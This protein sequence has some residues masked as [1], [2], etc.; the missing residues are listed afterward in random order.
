MAGTQV[1]QYELVTPGQVPLP[2]YVVV[3]GGDD[4][5]PVVSNTTVGGNQ[6]APLTIVPELFS[7]EFQAGLSTETLQSVTITALPA[8][9]TLTYNGAAVGV[10]ETIDGWGW[11][12]LVYTPNADYAGSDGFTWNGSDGA[13]S[14]AA[15]ATVGITVLPL[16]DIAVRG[17]GV[18]IS[19]GQKKGVAANGTALV[20]ATGK[21]S[22]M[23]TFTISNPG[24]LTLVLN[25]KS[26]VV[27]SGAK[28]FA[29]VRQPAMRIAPGG[30]TT[31]TV[32]FSGKGVELGLVSIETNDP[33]MPVFSF[34]VQGSVK[35]H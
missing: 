21:G 29:V 35:G 17:N 33:E 18:G 11:G 27:I 16:P 9:G 8:H 26:P 30:S 23:E 1:A 25:A 10:G 2:I 14:A 6:N 4:Q 31:F 32:R 5:A 15:D 22:V 7:N 19:A 20:I 3:Q 13:M 34:V 28:D 24:N 12:L